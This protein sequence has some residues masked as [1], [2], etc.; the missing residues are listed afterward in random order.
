MSS[1]RKIFY[2]LNGK[3]TNQDL[4]MDEQKANGDKGKYKE[5]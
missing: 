4:V 3:Y 2:L 5:K 1:K